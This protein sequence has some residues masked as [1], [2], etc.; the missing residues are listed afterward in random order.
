VKGQTDDQVAEQIRADGIHILFDL[1]GH[2]G[3]RM[4]LFAKKPAPVQISW[5]GYVGTTGLSAIDYVLADR[6]HVAAGEEQYY[7]ERVLRMPHGYACY[8]PPPAAPDVGP[9]PAHASARLTFGCFNNPAKYSPQLLDAWGRILQALPTS[10]LL[11][12]FGGL[13]QAGVRSRLY[14]EFH[15]RG[16]DPSR[17]LLEPMSPHFE[18]LNA[19][20][21]VDLALDT[22]PYSGG[23]TTCEALWM[24][25]PVVTFPGLT[26][27]GRHS[28]SHLYNAGYPQFV[29]SNW[30][31][32]V[33]LAVRWGSDWQALATVRGTMRKQVQRSALCDREQFARE[34]VEL[35]AQCWT[36]LM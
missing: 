20:N 29:A 28:T 1:V 26:F 36:S 21:R 15:Q 24:G 12:K 22:Q 10:Q 4:G 6:F 30:S 16:V 17:V 19:Y 18:A 23:L 7:S 25:V 11:L 13:D 8:L 2:F 27:A 14:G 31:G 9:L 35:L 34:F 5:L 33:E 3:E 32:Y